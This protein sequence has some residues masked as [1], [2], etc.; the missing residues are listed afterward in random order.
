VAAEKEIPQ[1]IVVT[2]PAFQAALAPLCD[3]RRAEGMRVLVVRT[4][5]VL[6]ARQIRDGDGELLKEHVHKLCRQAKGP[7]YVLLVGATRADKPAVAEKTV[8]PPL[9]GTAGRMKGKPSDNGYGCPDKQ[10]MPAVAV[11][12]FPA[13]TQEEVRQM[14]QKTLAFERDRSPG[15]W[16][17]RLTLLVG[18]PGGA[19][20]LEKRVAEWFVQKVAKTRFDRLH[21]VWAAR[22][23]MHVH[24][25]PF[26]VPDDRLREVSLRYLEEGQVFSFFLGHSYAGGLWSTG[27]RFLDRDDWAKLKIPGGPGVFFTSGCYSCQPDGDGGESYGVA[28]MRNPS[29]PVAVLGAQGESYA[30][31]GQLAI[32]GMLGCFSSPEPPPRLAD[33]WLAAKGG[34]ARGKMDEEDFRLYDEADGSRGKVPLA[35]QRLEHLEMWVLLGDPALRLPGRPPAIRLA[36]AATASAGNAVTVTGSVPAR[37]VETAVRLTLER[38]LGS[39]PVGLEPLPKDPTKAREVMM[40]NHERANSVVL[41]TYEVRPRD[42]RFEC[43]L[44]LP[45]K[46]PWPRLTVRAFAATK[47]E[48]AVGVLTLRVRK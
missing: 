38:P 18:N 1:W 33:Y 9:R 15:R 8:V 12:R 45:A 41:A 37:F 26:C 6:S 7:T 47:T 39:V 32:D 21:P 23:V 42:G 40:A 20:D 4:K 11:G 5:D 22:V 19:T 43:S 16:R 36:T 44:K 46:L 35:K 31:M 34:L 30:A 17:N 2:A 27:A 24:G 25:S 3:H 29:G 28:A 10:L 14:V 48:V 13:R